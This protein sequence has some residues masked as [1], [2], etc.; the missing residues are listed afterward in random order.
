MIPYELLKLYVLFFQCFIIFT[1]CCVK[2]DV[3]PKIPFLF[4]S[5][6]L[7]SKRPDLKLAKE[8]LLFGESLQMF[9][10]FVFQNGF[11]I[12]HKI[13]LG[14]YCLSRMRNDAI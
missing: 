6:V 2:I 10:T 5:V 14:R 8:D 1:V 3:N 13:Y 4:C 9:S 7:F 11:G 12:E